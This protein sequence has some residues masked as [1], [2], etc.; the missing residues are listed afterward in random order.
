[1]LRP[2]SWIH[3]INMRWRLGELPMAQPQ[4]APGHGSERCTQQ[5][6]IRLRAA[7]A[8]GGLSEDLPRRGNKLSRH[9]WV[10]AWE[11][12]VRGR[13]QQA[14][15]GVPARLPP[16]TGRHKGVVHAAAPL[17]KRLFLLS[18]GP[19]GHARPGLGALGVG[20]LGPRPQPDSHAHSPPGRLS[21]GREAPPVT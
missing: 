8:E 10:C 16:A 6:R 1:M 20:W 12:G 21:R 14:L 17:I 19:D 2:A 9:T 11:G 3:L 5:G 18:A 4:P 15:V 13:H 7:A